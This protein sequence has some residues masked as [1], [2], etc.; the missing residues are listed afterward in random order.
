MSTSDRTDS[1]WSQP[2]PGARRP[3][4]TREQIAEVALAIADAEGFDAVS[5]RR[6][7]SELR[8]GTMTLYHYVRTKDDLLALMDDAIMGEVLIPEGEFPADWRGATRAI[9]LRSH[10]AFL[11]HPWAL[12][13]LQGAI[14]GPNAL[15]HVEQSLAALANTDLD[16]GA[17]IQVTGIVD[18]YVLGHAMRMHEHGPNGDGAH[19][20]PSGATDI[21]ETMIAFTERELST[22]E[23]P[24]LTE[25]MGD[26][27]RGAWEASAEHFIGAERFERGLDA[28]LDG[29]TLRY[30]LPR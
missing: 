26:D 12:A 1:I 21:V 14:P 15:R 17:K 7:A 24:N 29:L 4:F 10:Q 6:I 16:V 8:A 30:D 22:G 13:A 18:D 23:Y 27:V 28:L 20:G 25:W 11:R 5:M 2:E 19:A 3:R 9:A